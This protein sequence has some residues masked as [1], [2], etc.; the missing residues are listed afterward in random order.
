MN[1]VALAIALLTLFFVSPPAQADWEEDGAAVCTAASGQFDTQIIPDGYGGAIVVWEDYRNGN[2]DIYAQRINAD[3]YALWTLDGVNVCSAQAGSQQRL[4]ICA[5]AGGGV[6]IAYE[7]YRTSNYDITV[8][9]LN[10]NGGL[11]WGANGINICTATGN[12]NYPE[13]V[14]DGAG[15][16]YVVWEDSRSGDR[17]IYAQRVNSSGTA[18]WTANGLA[19]MVW[20][21]DQKTPQLARFY[22]GGIVVVWTDARSGTDDIMAQRLY[23]NSAEVW[24]HMGV[25]VTSA[26]GNQNSPEL[27]SDGVG[28]TIVVWQDYRSGS[29]Y[30]IYAQRFSSYGSYAWTLNGL[31]ICTS[32]GNQWTP[33]IVSDGSGGAIMTW[34]DGRVTYDDLYAQRVSAYGTSLWTS[35]GAVVCNAEGQQNQPVMTLDEAGTPI[36]AW[37]D[38]RSGNPQV[39]AQKLIVS[40]GAS[41]W[42]ANGAPMTGLFGS[43]S[44]PA[45]ATDGAGGAIVAWEDTRNQMITSDIRIQKIDRHGYWGDPAPVIYYV[46]DVPGDQGGVV[47]VS[48]KASRLDPWPGEIISNYSVWRAIDPTRAAAAVAHGAALLANIE[49]FTSKP[50]G[51][52]V[53]MEQLGAL[54]FYWQ[55]AAT[56]TAYYLESYA[57]AVTTLFDSTATSPQPHY[58]QVIAHTASPTT[59]WVSKPDTGSSVDNLAPDP[60]VGLAG[61]QSYVPE[62]LVLAWDPNSERDLANYAVYRGL[63]ADFVP[64]PTNL[65]ATPMDTLLL[66]NG[67]EWDKGYYY[68]VSAIDIHGNES[69]YAIL[70]PDRITGGETPKAL[71]T[72]YLGQNFPN[73]F[74]PVTKIEFG[75]DANAVMTLRIYDAAGRLVRT[76]VEGARPAGRYS[77]LWDGRDSRGAAVAS[78]IYFYRLDAGSFTQTKKMVLLR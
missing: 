5:D 74:N 11:Q 54:T 50:G 30:D 61:E 8:Q 43:E 7:N 32:T 39:F 6:I 65:I 72:T 51:D 16:A 15:G 33:Q 63:S 20:T 26:T 28:G 4:S 24:D 17:D 48:W 62:G 9:R 3:G 59:Y 70:A 21:G 55:L 19:V 18:L 34:S 75:L 69:G 78:G 29:T 13:I 36:V 73:P 76:L 45:V 37:T 1:K 14:S 64:G 77:E 58:F 42:K 41:L 44:S 46:R 25:V 52:V 12:Q 66:D 56:V 71:L 10:K 53:R 57:R 60:P 27:M 2:N 67:W 23:D 38:W 40:N 35:G 68:K 49:E 31:A 47:N 22:S